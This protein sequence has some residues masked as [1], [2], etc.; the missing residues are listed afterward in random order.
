MNLSTP[1]IYLDINASLPHRFDT[2]VSEHLR[3]IVA[4]ILFVSLL[5]LVPTWFFHDF[6]FIDDAQNASLPTFREMGKIWLSGHLPILTSHTLFGSNF[7]LEMVYMPFLPQTIITSLAAASST[8][9]HTPPLVFAWLNLML[10]AIAAYWL[11]RLLR[12]SQ[13]YI[14]LTV[15]V[16]T[17]NPMFYYLF[18]TSWWNYAAGYAWLLLTVAALF[19][20]RIS[21]TPI[22]FLLAVASTA[23]LF[24]SAVAQYQIIAALF[25]GVLIALEFSHRR[26]FAV[27]LL[28]IS[29]GLSAFLIA[30]VPLM[31]E[32][33]LSG[34]WVARTGGFNNNGD[35][36]VPS[37]DTLLN[38]FNPFY[39]SYIH[40][41]DDYQFIPVTLGYAGIIGLIPLCF[42]AFPKSLPIEIK[43]LLISAFICF[44]LTISAS[45]FGLTRWPLRYLPVLDALVAIISIDQIA[46][47]TLIISRNR[48][49][50]FSLLIA[51]SAWMQLFSAQTDV[52]TH[53]QLD[54]CVLFLI[55][56]AFLLRTIWLAHK[57]QKSISSGWLIGISVAAWT[58][59]VLL[60]SPINAVMPYSPLPDHII[61]DC[62]I[63]SGYSLR[64]GARDHSSVPITHS[65][66]LQSGRFELYGIPA[67]NGYSPVGHTGLIKL[68]PYDTA[69]GFFKTV[70]T[71][72][73]IIGL[74]KLG[75]G[76]LHDYALFN[77]SCIF[78]A[79]TDIDQE[80]IDQLTQAGLTVKPAAQPG[81]LIIRP[82][83]T[84]YHQGSLSFQS[85]GTPIVFDHSDSPTTEWYAVPYAAY[86]RTLV[87]SRLYYP[88]YQ[89][90]INGVI[91]QP[92]PY[93]NTLVELTLP[94]GATGKLELTY[95]P[96]SWRYSKWSLLAGLLLASLVVWQ[97]SVNNRSRFSHQQQPNQ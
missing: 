65:A 78:A 50:L 45:Q 68:F 72:D 56:T 74:S 19:Q 27:M 73:N 95:L 22:S 32:Y 52:F 26:R 55:L 33:L 89:A 14:V 63:H 60:T 34:K 80:T 92:Q 57:A 61:D 1:R 91:L 97:L 24:A 16:L 36:L 3:F 11:A 48:I 10:T 79:S 9:L 38:F 96:V 25:Y 40:W 4:I 54:G 42:I 77:I 41:F 86:A 21:Q 88:G 8:S 69:H 37:L 30:A 13:G 51:S 84:H 94:A 39:K 81:L 6:F 20:L 15:F 66:Q 70:P 82:E 64:L 53:L 5:S 12:L 17:T 87:F 62:P 47:G 76:K 83:I 85:A 93:R 28:I 43:A 44:L 18:L 7:L 29:A 31:S 35:F 75:N 59:M 46:R 49:W 2:A 23:S 71:L 58:G 67:I 90:I